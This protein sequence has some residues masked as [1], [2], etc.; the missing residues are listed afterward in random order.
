MVI[1]YIFDT[2]VTC[3]PPVISWDEG[4]LGRVS[5]VYAEHVDVWVR[6]GAPVRFIWRDRLYP[7]AAVLEH[8]VAS[9]EWW[10]ERGMEPGQPPDHEFWRVE[11]RPARDAAPATYELRRN[12]AT[13]DWL[14]GRVWD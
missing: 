13:G 1:E 5:R 4:E 7:V 8:W 6:D 14:L 2:H 9:R 11:A 3:L 10:K 12:T